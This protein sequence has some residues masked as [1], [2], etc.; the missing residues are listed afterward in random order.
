MCVVSKILELVSL[1]SLEKVIMAS[2]ALTILART[3]PCG[4]E[5]RLTHHDKKLV[6]TNTL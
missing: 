3:G 1:E 6:L 2:Q 4:T 5:V